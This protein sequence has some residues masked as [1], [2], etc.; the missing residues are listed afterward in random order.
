MCRSILNDGFYWKDMRKDCTDFV[1]EC[2]ACQRYSVSRHGYNP[3]TPI[4]ARMPMDHLQV[5]LVTGF[6]KTGDG[7][8]YL[9]H[10]D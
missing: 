10:S 8:K 6:P 3:L 4:A 5:D 1:K 9:M 2:H 7:C